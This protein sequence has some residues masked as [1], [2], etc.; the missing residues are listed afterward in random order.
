[1][2]PVDTLNVASGGSEPRA[3]SHVSTTV[4]QGKPPAGATRKPRTSSGSALRSESFGQ[5][6]EEVGD[7]V[8]QSAR[9]GQEVPAWIQT[10]ENELDRAQSQQEDWVAFLEQH[11]RIARV[12]FS[13]EEFCS[14]RESWEEPLTRSP[15]NRKP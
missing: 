10:L 1:M 12:D 8:S 7:F 11:L 3:S 13:Y 15:G 14:Q 9:S 4:P 6:L 2:S 5:L